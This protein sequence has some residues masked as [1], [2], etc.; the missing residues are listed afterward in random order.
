MPHPRTPHS[1]SKRAR[2]DLPLLRPMLVVAMSGAIVLYALARVIVTL[3]GGK[4]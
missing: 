1:Y 3:M 2:A 4:W